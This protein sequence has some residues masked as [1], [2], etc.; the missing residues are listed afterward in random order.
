LTIC[1]FVVSSTELLSITFTEMKV[2]LS[3]SERQVNES[4]VSI[5]RRKEKRKREGIK[6]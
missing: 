1:I 2:M 6:K 5:I 3:E 4:E